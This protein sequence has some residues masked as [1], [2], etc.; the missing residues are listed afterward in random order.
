MTR[1]FIIT[2]LCAASVAAPA[3]ALAAS[4]GR[5]AGLQPPRSVDPLTIPK[6]AVSNPDGTWSWTDKQG[7]KW[8]YAKTPF[9]VS[10]VASLLRWPP[11]QQPMPSCRPA[12]PK[13]LS[14]MLTAILLPGRD[15]GRQEMDFLQ[16][17]LW[18][19]AQTP[20]QLGSVI[21]RLPTRAIRCGLSAPAAR[22]VPRSGKRR[23]RN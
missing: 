21:G 6:D 1:T 16:H 13:V 23:K 7:K 11:P 17:A 15:A 10:R 2:L 8:I 3:F 18:P 4:G 9:G 20:A 19:V 14:A 12:C 5:T 22:W